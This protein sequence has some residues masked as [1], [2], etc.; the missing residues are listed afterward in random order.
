MGSTI[1]LPIKLLSNGDLHV[2]LNIIF[3]HLNKEVANINSYLKY[4]YKSEK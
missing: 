3:D 4:L 2:N 1:V